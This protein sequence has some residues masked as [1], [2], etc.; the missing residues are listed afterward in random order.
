MSH[1]DTKDIDRLIEFMHEEVVNAED[2]RESWFHATGDALDR[3]RKKIER[4]EAKGK[5]LLDC[6]NAAEDKVVRLEGA[7]KL[8]TAVCDAAK[9]YLESDGCLVA[10]AGLFQAIEALDKEQT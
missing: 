5:L 6:W 1:F 2:E 10:N 8:L 7:N 4:L 9:V 3:Q